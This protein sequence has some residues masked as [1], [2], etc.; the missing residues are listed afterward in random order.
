MAAVDLDTSRVEIV[1]RH[2]H[3]PVHDADGSLRWDWTRITAEVRAG[4]EAGLA[5]GPV[6]SIG[7]D[8]WGVD[9]GL[10]GADGSLVAAPYCY[11]D[12]RTSSWREIAGRIG[13]EKLY[14]AT[15]IQ[16]MGINTIFQLAVHRRDE[17]DRARRVLMLPEL[18]VHALT[19]NEWG[20]RTSA[21][22]TQL[23]DLTTGDWS[24][25]LLDAIDVPRSLLPDIAGATT[26]AGE[27]N[28]VPVHLVG[29]HD[30]ASAVAAVITVF[31]SSWR[32]RSMANRTSS[33]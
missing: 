1:H 6:A 33:E 9:Y 31:R 10:I 17:L 15:G 19:G 8:A 25:E 7:V 3:E 24:D 2:A 26:L 11:R 23:V 21:G 13:V 12:A 27:W 29:G 32:C 14:T 30:T 5:R 18:M 16:L 22:T 4:L 28:G 20:E